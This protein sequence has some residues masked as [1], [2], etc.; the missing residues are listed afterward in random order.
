M[1]AELPEYFLS[2]GVFR[3]V[4]GSER[5]RAERA[6]RMADHGSGRVRSQAAAPKSGA[7]MEAQLGNSFVQFVR[8]QP[9]TTDKLMD[10]QKMYRP[11]LQVVAG[12]VSFDA[13]AAGNVLSLR[14]PQRGGEA[15]FEGGDDFCRE[16]GD[17]GVG[18]GR[19]AALESDAYHERIF[20]GGNI[21]AAE[22][23]GGFD[24]S[25]FGNVEAANRIG[26]VG[27]CDSIGEQQ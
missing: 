21:F 13:I 12:T 24:G 23:V 22:E 3:M 17:L 18:E 4:P 2:A 8:A 19:F 15:R 20:S 16:I 25:Y 9:A 10:R 27:E 14:G 6:D 11:V 26:D 5:F 7:Q 1:E